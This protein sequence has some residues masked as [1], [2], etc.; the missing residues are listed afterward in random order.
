M[1]SESPQQ[2]HAIPREEILS[3]AEQRARQEPPAMNIQQ[4][5]RIQE[6]KQQFRRLIDPGIMRPNNKESALVALKVYIQIH[7]YVL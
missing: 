4:L 6:T 5:A 3:A 7:S 2:S 1:T